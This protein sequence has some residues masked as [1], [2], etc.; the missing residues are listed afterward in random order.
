[1]PRRLLAQ[2]EGFTIIEVLFVLAIAGVMLFL[3]F[4]AIPALQR[5]S[6]NNQRNHDAATI[7]A[8]VSHYELNHSGN[9]PGQC[10]GGFVP[11]PGITHD[12]DSTRFNKNL[13][14]KLTYYGGGLGITPQCYTATCTIPGE[15]GKIDLSPNPDQLIEVYNYEICKPPGSDPGGGTITT[16][17]GAGYHNIVVIYDIETGGGWQPA[18]QQLD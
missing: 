15:Y 10:Y 11:P 12:C 1:M 17:S 16:P 6:R 4:Q 14:P 9:F 18:C 8:A 3:V 5:S 7:L 13:Q 2:K